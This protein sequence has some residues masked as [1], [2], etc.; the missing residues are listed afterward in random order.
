MRHKD[1][2]IVS[3]GNS[4]IGKEIAAGLMAKGHHVV[5]ACRNMD[6]CERVAQELRA[7]HPQG[8]CE[9]SRIDLED[10]RSVKAFASRHRAA[11]RKQGRP[12]NVLV[13]NAGIMGPA[14]LPD[15]TDRHLWANHL[16]PYLLT[17]LMLPAF[18]AGEGG[19]V[20]NVASRAHY[21]GS[22]R[23]RRE[24]EKDGS[25]EVER[26]DVPP[27]TAATG[28]PAGAAAGADGSSS[29]VGV[30][31]YFDGHPSHWFPQ[32][33]RSKLLNVL[34]TS[35]LQRRHGPE[36]TDGGCARIIAASVSPGMVGTSLFDKLPWPLCYAS[37]SLRLLARTPARG[38]ETAIW[39]ATSGEVDGSGKDVFLHDCRPLRPSPQALDPHLAAAVWEA[40][41]LAV[42]LRPDRDD[43][44]TEDAG[45]S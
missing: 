32:Y 28:G 16:G 1:Y 7:A 20:V 45:G 42:G 18:G 35:E 44:L 2:S 4:G 30:R 29:S 23:L 17:R 8:A 24:P 3:G 19:R 14:S 11:L 40:S 9:C 36:G 25:L 6:A 22:V 13:N 15:G 39:A 27:A 10:V 43:P 26:G 41:A 34:F 38:A 37:G 5:L 33:A 21:W 12:L 31:W